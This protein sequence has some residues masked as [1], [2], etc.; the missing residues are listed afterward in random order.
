MNKT[1]IENQIK[2][3][4]SEWV[5]EKEKGDKNRKKIRYA[6][7]LIGEKEYHNMM[8]AIF[9][10]WWSGGK[11]TVD[12]EKKLA[13][14]SDR[15]Y[16]LLCNAG[17]SANLLLMSAAKE[18]YFKDGD[19]IA[20]LSCGFPT[21]VNPIIQ[22]RMKPVF[23][24]IDLDDLNLNPELF[25]ESLKKDK[26]IKGLFVAHTLGFKTKITEI[27]DIARKYGVQVFFDNCD[28]YGTKYNGRPIQ[29]YGKAATF[30]FYVAHHL[31]MGEGGGIVTNDEDLQNT[32]R[33]FR[34]WG[35]Y[36]VSP[37]CCIRSE[38]PELF[39]PVTKLTKNC[40]LPSDYMV[41]YQFEYMGYNMKPLEIQSA[42]LNHQ[43]D[44][45]EEFSDIRR[46]NYNILKNFFKT[47]EGF[48]VW[49]IDDEVSPF[50]FPILLSGKLP[51][52]RKHLI[53]FLKRNDIETRL[54]FGGNLMRHPAYDNKK[55]LWESYGTHKNSDNITENFIM[56]GVSQIN[57]EKNME[58]I[59]NN[60]DKFLKQW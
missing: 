53:D 55:E 49:D 5:R 20:T 44:R 51:F 37:N 26:K 28:S 22:N 45:M 2:I 34:N 8:D 14:I 54:L 47:K 46:K 25:E 17:S 30:S 16:G 39:C 33:A 23:L 38:N 21:T 32:M 6:G 36:C 15:N 3:L 10:D 27:L 7:P 50:S 4:F 58:I 31:T 42:M 35:R 11:F 29:S 19:K 57:D 18:L 40:E 1:D 52:K 43:L 24:D 13:K 56:L 60:I 41:N 12:S 9:S 59:I 48:R